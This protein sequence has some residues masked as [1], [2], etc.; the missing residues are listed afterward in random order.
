MTP[1]ELLQHI[2][3]QLEQLDRTPGRGY[4]E[5][6]TLRVE[7]NANKG[8]YSLADGWEPFGAQWIQQGTMVYNLR[9]WVQTG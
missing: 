2:S 3:T 9:R 7:G 5:V 8:A 4:W 6:M 1:A